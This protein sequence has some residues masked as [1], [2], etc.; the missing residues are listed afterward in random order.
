MFALD[1]FLEVLLTLSLPIKLSGQVFVSGLKRGG[2]K[3]PGTDKV[4]FWPPL[5]FLRWSIQM[6]RPPWPMVGLLL[7]GLSVVCYLP[8]N[9]ALQRTA[10]LACLEVVGR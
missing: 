8:H 1:T 5:T 9:L 10:S 2:Y 7:R 6:K 3:T 4:L